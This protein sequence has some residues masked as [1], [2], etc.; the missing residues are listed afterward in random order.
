MSIY[1]FDFLE[2]INR[3]SIYYKTIIDI[4]SK[5]LFRKIRYEA[6]RKIDQSTPLNV[7]IML[8]KLKKPKNI[9]LKNLIKDKEYN[10][11]IISLPKKKTPSVITFTFLNQSK[12]LYWPIK[13]D[14]KNFSRLW[15][16][17]LHYF[18]WTRDWLNHKIIYNTWPEESCFLESLIDN[19][20]ASV[21]PPLS[22]GWHSY[23]L[24]LRI[25]NWF[26]LFTF[27][28]ELIN[29]YRINSLWE[30]MCWL[31]AHPE[32][33]H[34]GNHWIENLTA[35][36]IISLQFKSKFTKRISEYSLSH[37][38]KELEFQVLSDGGHEERS[39]SYHILIL[40]R[41]VELGFVLRSV[42]KI[43][44]P[45][46]DN[47]IKKMTF[48]LE[49]IQI[50]QSKYPIFNDSS[51]DI[52]SDLDIVLRFAISYLS[53]TILPGNSLR[54]NI[55]K[56]GYQVPDYHQKKI[57]FQPYQTKRIFPSVTD[58]KETGWIILRT[59]NKWELALKSGPSSP[60]HPAAHAHSDLLSFDLWHRG[61][62]IFCETGTSVYGEDLNRRNFERSSPAHNSLQIG[63]KQLGKI[64]WKEP[65][66]VWGTFRTG[67][68]AEPNCRGSG[69]KCEWVW[70][71]ASHDGFKSIQSSHLRWVGLKE[72]SE[73][74]I[75][76]VIIERIK[77]IRKIYWRRW[78][79]LAPDFDDYLKKHDLKWITL[80]NI[81]HSKK[82]K[83]GYYSIGFN[84]RIK[85]NVM[86]SEGTFEKGEHLLVSTLLPSEFHVEYK[87]SNNE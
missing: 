16:F 84:N 72:T 64:R 32:N 17:N 36:G 60:K 21:K 54:S 55:S 48:W 37:L 69:K 29:N 82:Y 27:C 45:W 2:L 24:S 49:N 26:W 53:N 58:L 59:S 46:L 41:L 50:N 73:Q 13:W 22:D 11:L 47:A 14:Q 56:L 9:T 71:C 68:K 42:N 31:Y 77:T 57:T 3:V 15:Q 23:T 65:V 25:R 51:S 70:C 76:L 1:K 80:D 85:R 43:S 78:F 6:R 33:C 35:L 7:L 38:K 28:P 52:C 39:A 62:P 4:D 67:R 20:I 8:Y 83:D 81:N 66:E 18:D 10:T 40:D 63:L 61:N 12:Y 30:Q 5:Y 44:T 79:H 87:K 74:K 86:I 75:I 19:W 34:G